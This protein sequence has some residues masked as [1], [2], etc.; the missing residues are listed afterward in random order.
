MPI[1]TDQLGQHLKRGLAPVYFVYGEEVLLVEESCRAIRD[2][3]HAAGY[4]D[5]QVFTVESGFDWNGLF[6]TT[7]SLSLFAERRLIEL[8]LPTGKPGEDGAK[9]L[10]EIATQSP[11]DTVFLVSC[12]KLEKATRAAKWVKA[13]EAAAVTVVAYPLEAAQW[14]AWIRRRMEAKGLKPGP[15]VVDLLAHLMEGNLLACA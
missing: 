11:A 3:A 5:R 4:L 6:A 1:N 9:I 13:L 10:V 14:P 2:T 7:Q 12:G 15:G 8:R